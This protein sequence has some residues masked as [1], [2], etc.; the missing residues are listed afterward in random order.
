MSLPSSAACMHNCLV[1]AEA[2]TC[3]KCID[4]WYFDKGEE[5]CKG[6]LHGFSA[7]LADRM[8]CKTFEAKDL[9]QM[10]SAVKDP[11]TLKAFH[12]E[13]SLVASAGSVE[14]W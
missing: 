2:S 10:K 8:R 14:V 4:G 13:R 11:F 6:L 9:F 3:D 1:C 5:M 7:Q 12:F